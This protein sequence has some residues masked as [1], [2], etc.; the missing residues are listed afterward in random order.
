[1][2]ISDIRAYSLAGGKDQLKDVFRSFKQPSV[3][4][5]ALFRFLFLENIE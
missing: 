5:E 3:R 4:N 2:G 1:M